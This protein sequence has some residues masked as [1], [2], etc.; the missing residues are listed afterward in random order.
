M[1][2]VAF[3][4][5]TGAAMV[6]LVVFCLVLLFVVGLFAY[7]GFQFFRGWIRGW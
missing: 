6:L 5:A 4:W 7:I 3:A 2:D 1:V